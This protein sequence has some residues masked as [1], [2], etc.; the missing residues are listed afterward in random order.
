MTEIIQQNNLQEKRRIACL[1][2]YHKNKDDCNFMRL[3][4][5]HRADLGKEFVDDIYEKHNNDM[6]I[7]KPII[8]YHRKKQKCEKMFEQLS[9]VF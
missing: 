5:Q 8:A 7:I 1:K 9:I 6:S 4:N 2:Y 3:K